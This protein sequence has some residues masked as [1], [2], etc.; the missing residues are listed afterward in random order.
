VQG[1]GSEEGMVD[2]DRISKETWIM[3]E[4]ALVVLREM[5]VVEKAGRGKVR[6]L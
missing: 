2:V 5:G 3:P 4:D 1:D 6:T